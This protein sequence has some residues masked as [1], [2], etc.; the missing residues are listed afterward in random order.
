MNLT[1]FLQLGPISSF[2][3]FSRGLAIHHIFCT[4]PWVVTS[5]FNYDNRVK[6]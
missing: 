2:D 6:S 4:F 5:N 3:L 1:L